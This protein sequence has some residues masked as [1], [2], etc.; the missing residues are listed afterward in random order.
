MANQTSFNYGM[1]LGGKMLPGRILIDYNN[2]NAEW[3]RLG[4]SFPTFSSSKDTGGSGK[5]GWTP[6]ASDSI[7]NLRKD[8]PV[9]LD[10]N[11]DDALLKDFYTGNSIAGLNNERAYAFN[12][13]APV[14]GRNLAV[15]GVRSTSGTP[16][17]QPPQ[18]SDPAPTAPSPSSTPSPDGPSSTPVS[19]GV[20]PTVAQN[21]NT[22]MIAVYP[23]GMDKDDKVTAQDRIKFTALEYI[24]SG[25]LST[26]SIQ[27]R[28]RTSNL[29]GKKPLGHVFLPV[30]AS[31]TDANSV[32]WQGTSL[33]A[34][35]RKAVNLSTGL[36]NAA[37]ANAAG[38]LLGTKLGEATGDV[39]KNANAV[40]VALAGEAVSI[41]NLLGR[42]GS[43]LNPNL[44]LLFTGPQ[45]RPF[46]FRFQM[47]AREQKEAENIKRIINFFKK[48]MA[49]RTTKDNIFL[50]APNTFLI[51]YKYKGK[52][53]EHPG[54][55]KIKECALLNCS[56]DYTPLGTYMTYDDG[57]M[58]SYSMTLSFQELE[59]IYDK[60]YDGKHSIGY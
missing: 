19:T 14:T 7:S 47:S 48:N 5:W 31:I 15:P 42:F 17:A 53:T 13:N 43:V 34:I 22:S 36:M 6:S 49:P 18:P 27:S 25:N 50:T 56:V 52:E 4:T 51:E 10:Y 41:Q 54:I 2:G 45:L 23:L 20:K 60:D 28:D 38:Q 11:S 39:I 58:V 8:L 40:K 24:A 12:K 1:K 33:N 59:P 37:D 57:T 29:E 9:G 44:E 35:E 30:Q 46:D 3:F 26:T 16:G 32:D 55:N 21:Q